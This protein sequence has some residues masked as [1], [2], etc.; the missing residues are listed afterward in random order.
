MK[1]KL[2]LMLSLV[3]IL[4]LLSTGY[5]EKDELLLANSANESKKTV[6]NPAKT[7]KDSDALIIGMPEVR[8]NFLPIYYSTVPDGYVVNMVYDSLISNN[9]QG[10]PIPHVAK[11]WEL[12]KD[13]KTYT[14]HLRDDVK[15]SD[16]EPLTANDIEFTYKVLCDSTYD[17]RYADQ[18]SQIV[19]LKEYR[20]GDA[21]NIEGIKVIDDYTISFTFT[22][23]LATHI[24]DCSFAIMP[25]H[26]FPDFKKGNIEVIKEQMQTPLGSGPYV[27]EKF[28][29]KQYVEFKANPNYFL[30]SPKVKK[31]IFKFNN[32]LTSMSEIKKGTIDVQVQISPNENNKKIINGTKFVNIVEYPQ[33]GYGYM[34]WNLRD[35]RLADKRVRQALTYGFNR[36]KFIDKYYN[37]Y[38][39]VCNV[40]VSKSSWAYTTDINEYKYDSNKAIAL[41]EKA[42]WKLG[43][44]GIRQKNGLK[45][46]FVWDT[47]TDSKYVET[48]IPML[49]SDWKKI[50]VKVEVNSIDF[51]TLIEKIYDQHK[52]D[53]YNM[54]WSLTI[55]PDA[56]ELFHSSQDIPSGNNSVGFRNEEND[57]LLEAGRKEFDLKKRVEIYQKWVKL[58][59]EE[60][61][62]MFLTQNLE[63]QAVNARVKNWNTSSFVEFTNPSI[64]SNIEIEQ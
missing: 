62:Y 25:K 41:L 64:I 20:D 59:N 40:P 44:D 7:R 35:P 56:L 22:E 21:E 47:Y 6:Q 18:V 4:S 54:A 61:P 46:S 51:I 2:V 9:K 14:F 42:G 33:N 37:G 53:I 39:K 52:F 5:A 27:L 23:A 48:M 32:N 34:G 15:F 12:S 38:A 10:N 58:M 3:L 24:W 30:R 45:L 13:H 50:G 16:G 17:G 57:K 28:E 11:N 43:K 60:L 55:D 1:K 8:G 36:Q 19:G 49:K 63:W 31:I 29:P 26:V